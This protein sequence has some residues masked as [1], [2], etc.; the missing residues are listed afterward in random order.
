MTNTTV[1]VIV[2][3]VAASALFWIGYERGVANAAAEIERRKQWAEMFELL[4]EVRTFTH[5]V[6][7]AFTVQ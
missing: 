6:S 2:G 3:T 7:K 1:A 5:T 4:T